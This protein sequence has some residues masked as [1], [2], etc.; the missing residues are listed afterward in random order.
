MRIEL[1]VNSVLLNRKELE[2]NYPYL[3]SDLQSYL[4]SH[5]TYKKRI[6]RKD[7]KSVST[8]IGE[9]IDSLNEE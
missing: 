9:I 2:I 5:K 4:P 8:M 7:S 6:A 3:L 1:Q